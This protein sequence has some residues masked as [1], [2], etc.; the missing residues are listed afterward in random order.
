MNSDDKQIEELVAKIVEKGP[1]EDINSDDEFFY[2]QDSDEFEVLMLIAKKFALATKA[3]K[4]S[5]RTD[6]DYLT[7]AFEKYVVQ[8]YSKLTRVLACDYGIYEAVMIE[9]SGQ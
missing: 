3:H 7:A 8:H 5:S 6:G 9:W 4:A 2:D 1:P